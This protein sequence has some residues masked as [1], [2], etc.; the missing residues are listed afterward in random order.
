[1]PSREDGS[2]PAR[3]Q[4]RLARL[5]GI[6]DAPPVDDFIEASDHDA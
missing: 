6:S 5:Y 1:M 4:G 3:I 2:L